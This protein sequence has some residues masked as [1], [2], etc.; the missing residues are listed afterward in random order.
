LAISYPNYSKDEKS[1][2]GIDIPKLIERI[3]F[4]IDKI[5]NGKNRNKVLVGHDWGSIFLYH[6]D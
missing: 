4:T 6:L 2:W 3:K 5:D 1:K